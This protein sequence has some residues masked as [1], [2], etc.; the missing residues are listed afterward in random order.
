[1]P[2]TW[3]TFQAALKE[4]WTD[5]DF[6]TQF[7]DNHPL[8]E[9]IERTEKHTIGE[10]ANVPLL[11]TRNGGFTVAGTAGSSA[12]NAAGNV[13]PRRRSTRSPTTTSRSRST[14]RR[15]CPRRAA[16]TRSPQRSTPSSRARRA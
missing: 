4:T 3:S 11:L 10:Y 15:S 14:I 6:E 7:Y 5:D 13:G 8:L 9:D 1:M 16:R 12:L 2:Q